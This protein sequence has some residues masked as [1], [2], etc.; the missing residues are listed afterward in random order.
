VARLTD[1]QELNAGNEFPAAQWVLGSHFSPDGH[2]LTAASWS[3]AAVVWNTATWRRAAMLEPAIADVNGSVI[4]T[5]DPSGRY[6]AASRGRTSMV[7]FDATTLKPVRDLPLRVQGLPYHAAFDPSGRRLV[8]VLDT[9]QALTFDVDTGARLGAS[10]PADYLGSVVFVDDDTLAVPATGR[11]Q[12]RLWHL[13]A[14]RLE[15]EACKMAGRNLSRAEWTR[16][17]PAGQPY[18][19][20]CPQF[21]EPPDDPTL[22]VEQP[23]VS[24]ETPAT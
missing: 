9:Q 13:D 5:F 8:V 14:R 7:L 17:G 12:L 3:G 16:L 10:V 18:R 1:L 19:P 2:W 6:L 11:G 24:I 4:P 15:A 23:P 20:T 22:S 21:G